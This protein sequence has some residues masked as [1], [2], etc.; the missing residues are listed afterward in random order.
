MIAFILAITLAVKIS[1]GKITKKSLLKNNKRNIIKKN[2]K[3][4]TANFKSCYGAYATLGQA[5]GLTGR[6]N[7]GKLDHSYKSVQKLKMK[8]KNKMFM[9]HVQQL[10]DNLKH[11]CTNVIDGLSVSS[12]AQKDKKNLDQNLGIK[13]H[14]L[15]D[16]G[17]E[18]DEGGDDNTGGD[19]TGGDDTGG[20]NTGGDN[21]GGDDTGGDDD[22]DGDKKDD[23]GK[24][25]FGLNTFA[26]LLSLV[27]SEIYFLV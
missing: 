4:S 26:L 17:D 24:L 1:N 23:D 27:I 2:N 14:Y 15:L 11:E 9:I 13:N 3:I 21:T 16:E 22:A 25:T 10:L 8:T 12:F 5:L 20:D 7:N 19:D 6:E 18:G